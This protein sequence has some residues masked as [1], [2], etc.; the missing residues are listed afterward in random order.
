MNRNRN[1]K[2][3][4]RINNKHDHFINDPKDKHVQ[5]HQPKHYATKPWK[6]VHPKKEEE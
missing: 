1:L 2:I 4:F 3:S 5:P 6:A